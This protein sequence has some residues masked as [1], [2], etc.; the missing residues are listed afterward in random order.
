MLLD[1]EKNFV[2]KIGVEIEGFRLPLTARSKGLKIMFDF[3]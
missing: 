1:K 2:Q 3:K